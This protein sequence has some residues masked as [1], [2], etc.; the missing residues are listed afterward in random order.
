MSVK[1]YEHT[2]RDY[3]LECAIDAGELVVTV[4]DTWEGSYHTLTR[5][6]A[7]AIADAIRAHYG[8]GSE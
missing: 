5:A 1:I 3:T 8:E 6:E 7:L 2:D 4:G